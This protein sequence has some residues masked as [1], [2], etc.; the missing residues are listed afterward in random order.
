MTNDQV[1]AISG[2]V[3]QGPPAIPLHMDARNRAGERVTLD[4][5]LA[6]ERDLGYGAGIS[7][8]APLGVTQ[9]IGRLMRDFGP[10]TFRMCAHFRV[11]ELRRPMGFCNPYFSVDDAVNDL[12]QAGGMVD[13]FDLAP[14]HVQR[15][16]VSIRA[17][18]G[19]KQDVLVRARGP[20]RARKGSAHP[21]APHRAAAAGRAVTGSRCPCACRAR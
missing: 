14:L 20:R 8:V 21:R 15:V 5:L 2:K 10:V 6:D 11:R 17:R 12:S 18:S 3:G 4:S 7:F 19:V 1:D 9:A 16:A 13:F